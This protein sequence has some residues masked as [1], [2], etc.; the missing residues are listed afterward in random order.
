MFIAIFRT[1]SVLTSFATHAVSLLVKVATGKVDVLQPATPEDLDQALRAGAHSPVLC[2]SDAPFHGLASTVAEAGA[3]VLL[4]QSPSATVARGLAHERGLPLPNAVRTTSRCMATLEEASIAGNAFRVLFSENSRTDLPELIQRMADFLG[5]HP[6]TEAMASFWSQLSPGCDP[7]SP[8]F[9]EDQYDS[10]LARWGAKKAANAGT[11]AD[12][13]TA[14][15]SAPL[16]RALEGYDAILEGKPVRHLEWPPEAFFLIDKPK[17]PVSGA[18]LLTGRARHL[19]Y[20][21]YF[22]LPRGRWRVTPELE[23][24]GNVSGNRLGVEVLSNGMLAEGQCRLPASGRFQFDIVVDAPDPR[25][26][27]EVRFSIL[28]GAIEGTLALTRVTL[29]RLEDSAGRSLITPPSSRLEA[30]M[31]R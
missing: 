1:P 15:A 4:F 21:P 7:Q 30:L 3:P 8:L 26:A 9:L 14:A 25:R 5:L 18:V 20:G 11:A 29:S 17:T 28:E 22:N 12:S 31:N 27:V 13:A 2:V 10:A 19:I 24:S 6:T 16:L 23:V